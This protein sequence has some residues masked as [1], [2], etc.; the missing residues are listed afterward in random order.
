[1]SN[2]KARVPGR[3]IDRAVWPC[4]PVHPRGRLRG[5]RRILRTA[6][7]CAARLP[8]RIAAALVV[9]SSLTVAAAGQAADPPT[10]PF[11]PGEA[12]VFR[13]T[14]DRFG[15]IGTGSMRVERRE[16]VRGTDAYLLCF[17][18]GSRVGPFRIEDRTRSWVDPVTM[19]S[20]RYYKRE[21]SPLGGR[22][23]EVEI[24]PG[25]RRWTSDDGDAGASPTD[26]PLDELSFLYFIRTLPLEDGATYTL[27]RHFDAG[28]NPVVVQVLGRERLDLPIGVFRTI[29]VEMRVHDA[30]RFGGE[31]VLRLYLTDDAARY[32]VRIQTSMPFA[33]ALTLDLE[34][35]APGAGF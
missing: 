11:A 20:L 28:R 8:R 29:A 34:S 22:S 12:M 4:P 21:R 14:S 30:G 25:E 27:G 16:R 18:F 17:D 13:V 6:R 15:E 5:R 19:A 3:T 2:T 24:F 31:G 32:P 35:L 9:A 7:A 33:G 1:M 23:E 10:L 26:A